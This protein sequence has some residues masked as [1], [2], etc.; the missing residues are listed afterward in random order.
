MPAAAS[1][2]PP[3][4]TATGE[5][6]ARVRARRKHLGLSQERL[7]E[8]TSL[9]WSYIGQVERGQINLSL[10]NIIKIA[11]VLGIDPGDLVASLPTPPDG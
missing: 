5:F 8:G 7:A 10:H 6:G 11:S 4:S 3:L 2:K 1:H 9:H